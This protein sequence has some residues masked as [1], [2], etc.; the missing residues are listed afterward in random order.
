M[1]GQ[2]SA[3]PGMVNDLN[4]L[5]EFEMTTEGVRPLNPQNQADPSQ[6][7]SSPE[8]APAQPAGSQPETPP[9][10]P[11]QPQTAQAGQPQAP[12]LNP[13]PQPVVEVVAP[14]QAPAPAAAEPVSP[15][16]APEAPSE[17]ET[18]ALGKLNDFLKQHGETIA[19]ETRRTV[20]SQYDRQAT[21]VNRQL[22]DAKTKSDELTNEIRTL[23]SRD[24]TDEERAKVNETWAQKDERAEL[25]K[26]RGE[27]QGFQKTI[28]IDSLLLD[29]NPYGVERTALEQIETTEEME[30]YCEQQKSGSLEKRLAEGQN[31]ATVPSEAVVTVPEATPAQ[32]QQPGAPAATPSVPATASV[33][34]AP[35]VP[36]GAQAP[37]DVGTGGTAPQEGNKFSEEQ[38]PDAFRQNLNNMDWS[39]VRVRQA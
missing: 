31:S 37:S 28:F 12:V 23:Q 1:E 30:L 13:S 27:L 39:R 22:S 2:S 3:S 38:N 24:L 32:A 8:G 25:D 26:Y 34:N 5:E 16:A 6:P 17:E 14:Q 29:Y 21:Q 35:G 36:A 7:A 19:E 10:T 15:V 11:A 33:P 9:Q 4:K 20:Q 18:A